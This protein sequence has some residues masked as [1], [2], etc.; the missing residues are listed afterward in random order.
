MVQSSVTSLG[1]MVK[2]WITYNSF[3]GN[4]VLDSVGYSQS[5]RIKEQS[6]FVHSNILKGHQHHH[7]TGR[8]ENFRPLLYTASRCS[9]VKFKGDRMLSVNWGAAYFSIVCQETVY[10]HYIEVVC[11]FPQFGYVY[12]YIPF[13]YGKR[14]T[15][16]GHKNCYSLFF[17]LFLPFHYLGRLLSRNLSFLHHYL[18]E[19]LYSGRLLPGYHSTRKFITS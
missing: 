9:C 14:G 16:E 11:A 8:R 10:L 13:K 19:H 17:F 6:R 12:V 3:G 5:K 2:L 4:E 15:F 7:V 1:M 18:I